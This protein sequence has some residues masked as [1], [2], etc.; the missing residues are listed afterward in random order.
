MDGNLARFSHHGRPREGNADPKDSKGALLR[1]KSSEGGKF[2]KNKR[3]D[4]E[5]FCELH[6]PNTT[7]S[8]GEC[9]VLLAQA[10]KMK[11]TWDTQTTEK[12]KS[13]KRKFNHEEVNAMVQEAVQAAI[14]KTKTKAFDAHNIERMDGKFQTW[15]WA[16]MPLSLR[17][18][19][20]G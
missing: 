13:S 7:H 16:M 12:K 6:G 11:A 15:N 4:R 8:T 1:A 2:N 14:K 5:L 9:K 20:E 19:N 3:K 17:K 18:M 10:K